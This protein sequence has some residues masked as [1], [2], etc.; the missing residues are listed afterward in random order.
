MHEQWMVHNNEAVFREFLRVTGCSN[1]FIFVLWAA[2]RARDAIRS[3]CPED[4]RIAA[5]RWAALSRAEQR[6]VFLARLG[7]L[8]SLQA[9]P[10]LAIV[11]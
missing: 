9:S 7:A 3:L 4:P 6:D 1:R 5:D 8:P 10:R 2:D 11:A